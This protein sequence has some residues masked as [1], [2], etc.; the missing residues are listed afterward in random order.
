MMNS[1]IVAALLIWGVPFA[2]LSVAGTAAMVSPRART[3]LRKR[4]IAE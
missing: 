1:L 3:F 2:C 4:L